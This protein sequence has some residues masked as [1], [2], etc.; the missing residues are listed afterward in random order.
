MAE[1]VFLA[2]AQLI[3]HGDDSV[4]DSLLA[5]IEG[6]AGP[7]I[8]AVPGTYPFDCPATNLPMIERAA[9]GTL[10]AARKWIYDLFFGFGKPIFAR[11]KERLHLLIDF[12][13]DEWRMGIRCIIHV[14]LATICGLL[15]G[16]GGIPECLLIAAVPGIS[17]VGEY[18]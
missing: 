10:N 18:I 15:K 5:V 16:N 9:F 7:R 6:I 14:L 8:P 12:S 13:V 3:E 2:K 1:D 11:L 17:L 4:I